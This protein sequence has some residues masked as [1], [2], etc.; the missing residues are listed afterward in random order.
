MSPEP[1]LFGA[2]ALVLG[3]CALGTRVAWVR[4]V[5]FCFTLGCAGAL[6]QTS[7][8]RPRAP[9]F[10]RPAGTVVS[11]KFDEPNAIYLWVVKPGERTPTSYALPWS[12]RQAAQLQKAAEQAKKQGEPLRAGHGPRHGMLASFASSM[13]DSYHFY[14]A[15][16]TPLPPKEITPG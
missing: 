16:H 5:A 3:G 10:D 11:Y 6:W 13:H 14:P 9:V 12:E 8:G 15:H 7:L 4:A 1:I 2:L